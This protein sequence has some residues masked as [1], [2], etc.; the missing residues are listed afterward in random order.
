MADK[1]MTAARL[2]ELLENDPVHRVQFMRKWSDGILVHAYKPDLWLTGNVE[3]MSKPTHDTVRVECEGQVPR[4]LYGDVEPC[5]GK[6]NHVFLYP[7]VTTKSGAVL[8]LPRLDRIDEPF[9]V[10]VDFTRD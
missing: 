9:W 7:R 4:Q 1:V 2:A 5:A 6:R 8:Q 3:Y 10:R